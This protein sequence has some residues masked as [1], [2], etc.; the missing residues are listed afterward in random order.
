MRKIIT[1]DELKVEF[2]LGKAVKLIK[3]DGTEK[4]VTSLRQLPKDYFKSLTWS[5]YRKDYKRSYGVR[6]WTGK[7]IE[8]KTRSTADR[9]RRVL[10][11]FENVYGCRNAQS[12][13]R[14]A[15]FAARSYGMS[16]GEILEKF[17]M[18][19]L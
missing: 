15:Y 12:M 7:V 2:S 16:G 18:E 8:F 11:S 10:K 1:R 13:E 14:F 5:D 4:I 17:M 9:V 6:L 19:E 3:N